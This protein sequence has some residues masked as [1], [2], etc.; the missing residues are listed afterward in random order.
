M[1]VGNAESCDPSALWYADGVNEKRRNA[2]SLT[3]L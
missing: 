1:N 2:V 3:R